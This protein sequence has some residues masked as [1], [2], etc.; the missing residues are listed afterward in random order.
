MFSLK[1]SNRFLIFETKQPPANRTRART[2]NCRCLPFAGMACTE[3]TDAA[4]A[5][6]LLRLSWWPEAVFQP[7]C[8]LTYTSLSQRETAGAANKW[9]GVERP[10]RS[11]V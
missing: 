3:W 6:G 8:K 9:D 2:Q 10:L 1:D 4:S 11:Q 7:K 5:S